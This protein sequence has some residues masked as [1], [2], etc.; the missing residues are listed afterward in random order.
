MTIK[1]FCGEYG[2]ALFACFFVQIVTALLSYYMTGMGEHIT[3]WGTCFIAF[4]AAVIVVMARR[5]TNPTT[6]DLYFISLGFLL[7]WIVGTVVIF[8][9]WGLKYGIDFGLIETLP[10]AL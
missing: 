6:G 1:N 10:P 9:I 3:A 4:W 5:P 8:K 2:A 7:V